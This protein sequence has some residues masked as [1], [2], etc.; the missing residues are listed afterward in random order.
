VLPWTPLLLALV[1]GAVPA[2][3]SL[4]E[5]RYAERIMS[6]LWDSVA[7]LDRLGDL[8][9]GIF[10]DPERQLVWEHVVSLRERAG[11]RVL[12]MVPPPRFAAAHESTRQ[13]AAAELD[14]VRCYRAVGLDGT[15]GGLCLAEE[16]RSE[17]VPVPEIP[18]VAT[19]PMRFF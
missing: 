16:G 7:A 10:S 11:R 12:R 9:D 18:A 3:D 8:R 14:V 13:W 17:S 6:V 2:D 1:V 5:G 4:A 15:L 19:R